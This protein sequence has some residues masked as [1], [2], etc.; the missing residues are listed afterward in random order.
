[1]WSANIDEWNLTFDGSSTHRRGVVGIVLSTPD[2]TSASLT[3][4]LDFPYTNYEIE[5]EAFVVSL[6]P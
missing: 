3:Y 5:Y 1:M 6:L 4:K 2:G